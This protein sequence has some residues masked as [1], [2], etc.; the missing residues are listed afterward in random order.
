M[1]RR[2]SLAFTGELSAPLLAEL[3]EIAGE[4][5]GWDA[6]TQSAE[7]RAVTEQLAARHGVQ[8]DAPSLVD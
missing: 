1:Q 5:L 3:A 6:A 4:V 8:L 2:T 7:V